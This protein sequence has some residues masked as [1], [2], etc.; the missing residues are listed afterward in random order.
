MKK[1]GIIS[2]ARMTSTRLPGKVLKEANG[3]PLLKYHVD[4]VQESGYPLYIAT[5]TNQTDDPIVAFCENEHI[6]FYRGSESHVLSRYYECAKEHQLDV[7][8]RV[9]SDCPLIDGKELQ[10]GVEAF[11][12]QDNPWLYLSNSLE[13][14]YPRGF[15]F[16]IFS[17]QGLEQA[18]EKATTA[19]EI[20]HV[21]PYLYLGKDS[22]VVK[23]AFR[24]VEDK[25]AY[26]VTV[27]TPA[28]F[29]L[30][31]RLIEDFDA[32]LLDVKGIVDVLDNQADLVAINVNIEQKKLGE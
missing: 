7:I 1:I 12:E 15:D 28:D 23:Q 5:T 25:S 16:E 26:R 3:L 8:V 6:S 27:D 2:Q 10:R 17:F 30:V 9:T 32:H 19:A 22:K 14:T 31:R 21:T 20:E 4:R 29:E 24:Y 13:R 11:L 18:F